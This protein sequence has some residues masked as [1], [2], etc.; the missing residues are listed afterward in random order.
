MIPPG[1]N[2]SASRPRG[3]DRVY[4][5]PGHD[6]PAAYAIA[7]ITSPA[8]AHAFFT[9]DSRG[10]LIRATRGRRRGK[11]NYVYDFAAFGVTDAQDQSS[12]FYFDDSGSVTRTQDTRSARR[13]S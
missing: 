1:S 2:S 7:S 9:Y 8:G 3:H 11:L 10:R 6:G 12:T 4:L 13:S 5:Y